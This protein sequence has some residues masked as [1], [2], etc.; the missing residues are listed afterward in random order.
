MAR[1]DPA[2]QGPAAQL[3]SARRS[4]R[5]RRSPHHECA[6]DSSVRKRPSPCALARLSSHPGPRLRAGVSPVETLG[7]DDNAHTA[8]ASACIRDS[9]RRLGS[10]SSLACISGS[11]M[12]HVS[13]EGW[14]V[15]NR[16]DAVSEVRL[17][18]SCL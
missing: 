5:A 7:K 1:L 18:W 14:G 4:L 16:G 2:A 17:W 8:P 15:D 12:G 9:D 6:R 13:P 3:P 10:R 11:K